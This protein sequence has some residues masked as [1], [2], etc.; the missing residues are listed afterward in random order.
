MPRFKVV[1]NEGK[2]PSD[3]NWKDAWAAAQHPLPKV[4]VSDP[5]KNVAQ[6]IPVEA[7]TFEVNTIN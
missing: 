5:Y 3:V 7:L 1:A 2:I 6:V 4:A